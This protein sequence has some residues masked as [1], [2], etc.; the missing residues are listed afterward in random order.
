MSGAGGSVSE[1]MIGKRKRGLISRRGMVKDAAAAKAMAM[2]RTRME[3]RDEREGRSRRARMG[4]TVG[5]E[6]WVVVVDVRVERRGRVRARGRRK[7]YKNPD[8]MDLCTH[9]VWPDR[10][11]IGP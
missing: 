9:A 8:R 2:M 7:P 6:W 4:G 1:G 5:E 11:E 10:T 3:V